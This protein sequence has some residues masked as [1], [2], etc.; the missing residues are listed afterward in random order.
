MVDITAHV[1]IKHN[2]D[3]SPESH[4]VLGMYSN[5]RR[6]LTAALT[7]LETLRIV[8]KQPSL[9]GRADS[10]FVDDETEPGVIWV[11]DLDGKHCVNF[12]ITKTSLKES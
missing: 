8:C 7:E 3:T 2:R 5:Y 4:T 6:A 11:D 1:V 10:I 12:S 9:E